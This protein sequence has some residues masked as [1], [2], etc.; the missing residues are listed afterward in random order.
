LSAESAGSNITNLLNQLSPAISYLDTASNAYRIGEYDIAS[1]NTQLAVPI[2]NEVKGQAIIEKETARE[3]TQNI[4]WLTIVFSV[5]GILVFAI[6]L[7]ILWRVI[8][9]NYP[10]RIL[11]AKPELLNDETD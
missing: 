3:S 6:A 2:A 8:K 7:L 9:R 10:K 11:N 5:T 4:F 1:T